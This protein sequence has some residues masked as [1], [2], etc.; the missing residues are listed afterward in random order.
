M[1]D[2]NQKKIDWSL[3]TLPSDNTSNQNQLLSVNP[4]DWAKSRLVSQRESYLQ[5]KELRESKQPGFWKSFADGFTEDMTFGLVDMYDDADVWAKKSGSAGQVL[6]MGTSML[7]QSAALSSV[8][9]GVGGVT[10]FSAKSAKIASAAKKYNNAKKLYQ[11]KKINKAALIEQQAAALKASGVGIPNS[12]LAINSTQRMY[13]DRFMRLAENDIN[14]AKRFVLGTEIIR[15][16]SI[17]SIIGQ[18]FIT[19]E[20][21]GKEVKITDRLKYG[22]QDFVAGGFFGAGRAFNFA[23]GLPEF[24][25]I[26]NEGFAKGS[27]YFASGFTQSLPQKIDQDEDG[28]FNLLERTILG[29]V[30]TV[31]GRMMRGGMVTEA[32]QDVHR[33]LRTIGVTDEAFI[34]DVTDMSLRVALNRGVQAMN[35]DFEGM[36][37]RSIDDNK[38]VIFK[39]IKVEGTGDKKKFFVDYDVVDKSLNNKVIDSKTNIEADKF[40]SKHRKPD[41]KLIDSIKYNLNEDGSTYSWFK[42]QKEIK[43]FLSTN[44][45]GILTAENPAHINFRGMGGDDKAS[46]LLFSDSNDYLIRELLRRGYKRQ[47]ILAVRGNWEGGGENSFIVKNLK[48]KD[49]IELMKIF[50]QKEI[51][52]NDK[53]MRLLKNPK[54]GEFEFSSAKN[55]DSTK[56]GKRAQFNSSNKQRDFFST[57]D[58]QNGKKAQFRIDY[59]VAKEKDEAGAL[60]FNNPAYGIQGVSS[61]FLS[62]KVNEA[63]E[64]SVD[65]YFKKFPFTS[66]RKDKIYQI[67]EM[68]YALK[69]EDP[70]KPFKN[71]GAKSFKEALFGVNSTTKM[72]SKEL[73]L[74][75]SL[76]SGQ[77]NYF[78]NKFKNGDFL[79]LGDIPE[80]IS[81]NSSAVNNFMLPIVTKYRN[82]AKS[83]NS[84]ALKKLASNLEDYSVRKYSLEGEYQQMRDRQKL[85]YESEGLTPEQ[86]KALDEDLGYWIETGDIASLRKN[87]ENQPNVLKAINAAVAE[88]KSYTQRI[89]KLLQKRGIQEFYY[90]KKTKTLELRPLTVEENFVSR[91]ITEEAAEYFS[92]VSPDAREEIISQIILRDKRFSGKGEYA[93]LPKSQQRDI[94]SQ[95]FNVAQP[96]NAKYGVYGQQFARTTDLP[97]ML[98][99]DRDGR[100]IKEVDNFEYV[101]GDKINGVEVDRA[102]KVYDMNYAANMDRYASKVANLEAFSYYFGNRGIFDFKS[103][104]NVREFNKEFRKRLNEIERE[105]INPND[106][107]KVIDAIDLDFKTLLGGNHIDESV[108]KYYSAITS[109]T[110]ALGLS[111][112]RSPIKNVLLGNVQLFTTFGGKRLAQTYFNYIFD[113][114][115]WKNS[116]D[117]AQGIN[118]LQSGQRGVETAIQKAGASGEI[119]KALTKGMSVGEQ[120]NRRVSVS[121]GINLAEDALAVLKGENPGFFRGMSKEEAQRLLS[122]TFELENVGDI[123]RNGSFTRRQKDKILFMS[124][125]TTQGLADPV[126]VPRWMSNRYVKPLTLFYRIAYRITENVYKNAYK[127]ALRGDVGPMMRYVAAT[128]A[129]GYAL[130][131]LY[132]K[133]FNTEPNKFESAGSKYWSYFVD[134]EGLGIFSTVAQFNNDA[135]QFFTPAIV[136]FGQNLYGSV[137]QVT[138]GLLFS[139]TEAERNARLKI[140]TKDFAS[141]IP[142]VNDILRGIE[143]NSEEFSIPGITQPKKAYQEVLN[144]RTQIRNYDKEVRNLSG[145]M[146]MSAD[147]E[148]SFMYRQIEANVYANR[149]M[150]KKINDF[151]AAVSYLQHQYELQGIYT[152]NQAYNKAFDRVLRYVDYYS[153]PIESRVSTQ[154]KDK[155]ISLYDDFTRRLDSE[156]IQSLK[157]LEKIHRVNSR[158]YKNTVNRLKNKYRP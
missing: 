149:P 155:I 48:N 101:K 68:E 69:L 11:A 47:D 84:P 40:F 140:A 14:S 150:D 152:K 19:E 135:S 13:L 52:M 142:L 12:K 138:D 29:G 154:D 55:L 32:V 136:Q 130:Q 107:Q 88:H 39:R 33:G 137:K 116:R 144:L 110:A 6:G 54:T 127:P 105:I 93:S 58:L 125:A 66:S 128:T 102:I 7:L 56:V 53:Y 59:D 97:P 146:G 118:A 9:F 28:G 36:F 63:F 25:K 10:L 156:S 67:K 43:Q 26:D 73:D 78:S 64:S 132:H 157:E 37:F 133:A 151:Y 16:G 104:K 100:V 4:I 3:S 114:Q 99:L 139:D 124:H 153:K 57:V 147:E 30:S 83:T 90:N 18:K 86:V 23:K 113:K 103:K 22:V 121:T 35:K 85:I 109:W 62:G 158:E 148:K 92:S 34:A 91:Q 74:Y 75:A 108:N 50:G 1:Q 80:Q 98:Y 60:I 21:L 143:N 89:A 41:Y 2:I 131:T 87:Y 96:N 45:Y 145:P 15:E 129:G 95:L 120:I 38:D 106:R 65:R 81:K 49:A 82:F 17:N 79:A 42:N 94:A 31:F 27:L 117:L 134:G 122:E 20:N 61:K 44:K 5:K 141:S 112:P 123:I 46:E 24:S 70:S 71:L 111:S 76:L 126:F 77:E 119:Q 72:S 115:A 8:T 51:A